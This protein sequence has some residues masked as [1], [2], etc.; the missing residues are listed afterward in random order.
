[1]RM[2]KRLLVVVTVAVAVTSLSSAARAD[3]LANV[4]PSAVCHDHRFAVG[5]WAQ[6]GTSWANRRYVVNVYAPSG[7]R[8]LHKAGHAPTSQW[9]YWHPKAWHLG[10]YR[11]VYK[12]WSNGVVHYGRYGTRANSC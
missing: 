2:I 6:P 11:T 8:V 3:T 4:P 7:A 9:V 10:K 1:M 5:V 12:V